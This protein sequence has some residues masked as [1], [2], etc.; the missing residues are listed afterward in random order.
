MRRDGGEEKKD[1]EESKDEKIGR[2][3]GRLE[4]R[5]R[6]KERNEMER[7]GEKE[8]EMK[9]REGK[10]SEYGREMEGEQGMRWDGVKKRRKGEGKRRMERGEKGR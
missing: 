3:G 9:R 1:G 10:T 4:I 5:K 8:N 2:T 7:G 6:R